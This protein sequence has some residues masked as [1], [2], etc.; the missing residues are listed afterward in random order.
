MAITTTISP[1]VLTDVVADYRMYWVRHQRQ[2]VEDPG[3]HRAILVEVPSI[4]ECFEQVVVD[5]FVCKLD[6]VV[7]AK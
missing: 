2:I 6:E 5:L 4:Y 1:G 7:L 3:H